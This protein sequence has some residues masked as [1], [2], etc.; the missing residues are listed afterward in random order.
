MQKQ[1]KNDARKVV[2]RW[3]E[4]WRTPKAELKSSTQKQTANVEK[5][6]AD[7]RSAIDGW[8]K[9]PNLYNAEKI[10]SLAAVGIETPSAPIEALRQADHIA[11]PLRNFSI[12]LSKPTA[13]L[14]IDDEDV[15]ETRQKIAAL[16]SVTKL[17][18]R[19]P[20]VYVEVARLYALLGQA[21]K[22]KENLRKAIALAPLNRYVIRSAA[23]FFIHSGD[24]EIALR[25]LSRA[26]I[27]NDPW[28]VAAE[29]ATAD[30]LNRHGDVP[31]KRAR[32][33]ISAQLSP[34][35]VSELNASLATL[36]LEN[37]NI[38]RAKRLFRESAVGITDNSAAQIAWA[39][40]EHGT[41]ID[42]NLED[43][44]LSFE[45]QARDTFMRRDFSS[46]IAAV[47]HWLEDE[48]FSSRPALHGSF[49]SA[50]FLQDY[51]SALYFS[52]KGLESN[53]HNLSLINNAAYS[54]SELGRPLE[55]LEML[56][57]AKK[58]DLEDDT[59]AA[60]KA[61]EG[62]INF[63]LGRIF[64]AEALY[65]EALVLS[66]GRKDKS[67]AEIVYIHWLKERMKYFGGV[68]DA[69]EIIQYFSDNG[70]ASKLSK[71]IFEALIKDSLMQTS[72]GAMPFALEYIN[73]I[74]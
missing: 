25:V 18:P 41:N 26:S 37:G 13:E 24:P 64:E 46:H 50:E 28:I 47:R 60:L 10:F 5:L 65:E 45:A 43:V 9:D 56:R 27:T 31:I 62:H 33:I 59:S 51:D 8:L 35:Q 68:D 2:P 11:S 52:L 36:E 17:H 1:P 23:R 73:G 54:Y 63:T 53:P 74:D 61:T 49:V 12:R 21:E 40:E 48:A 7:S 4:L 16:K 44:E 38:K 3:R 58:E 19:N 71:H 29:I 69:E 55:A 67:T 15:G 42:I 20:I 6:E 72:N 66:V 30:L 34:K 14:L 32:S 22:A 70:R 57:R 39:N